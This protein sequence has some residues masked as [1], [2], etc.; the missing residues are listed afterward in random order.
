MEE[1]KY[2]MIDPRR[3]VSSFKGLIDTALFQEILRKRIELEDIIGGSDLLFRVG[4]RQEKIIEDNAIRHLT[5]IEPDIR[6]NVGREKRL[7][8][9]RSKE[10]WSHAKE[11][12]KKTNGILTQDL[13]KEISNY[14]TGRYEFRKGVAYITRSEGDIITP[15]VVS[16]N[17]IER[18]LRFVINAIDNDQQNNQNPKKPYVSTLE[19]AFLYHLHIA[20]VHPF[21]DGNGRV[22]RICQNAALYYVG[23]PAAT[24]LT[25]ERRTY[26]NLIQ[27]ALVGFSERRE[28]LEDKI[29]PKL[30]Q[31]RDKEHLRIEYATDIYLNTSQA[32]KTFYE[33]LAK[34]VSIELQKLLNSVMKVRKSKVY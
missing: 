5:E 2:I 25:E 4:R 19:R 15:A 29:I 34:K 22:A 12:F 7:I 6:G 18:E 31:I 10:A 30:T 27:S 14:L 26:I 16:P 9:Q 21:D 11:G 32:E 8:L 3:E 23:L 17:S 13:I 28:E 24:V 33:F 20:R 1:K